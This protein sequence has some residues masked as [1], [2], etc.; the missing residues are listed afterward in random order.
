VSGVGQ[1]TRLCIHGAAGRVGRLLL[2][3]AQDDPS[4]TVVAAV[5]RPGSAAV[6]RTELELVGLGVGG[7]AIS[8]LVE[9]ALGQADVLIDFSQPEASARAIT[10]AAAAQVAI[11][12]GTTGLDDAAMAAI[13]AAAQRVAVVVA[14]N[15]SVGAVILND[16]ARKAAA[17]LGDGF[18]PEIV[19]VHHR[20]KKDA[21][22]GTA[23]SLAEALAFAT[24]RDLTRE[25]VTG[26]TGATGERPTA[27]LGVL[28]VR[29]GDVVGD[30]TVHFLGEG[31]RL[32][33]T[34]RAT[35]REL[36]ARGAIRA[37]RWAMGR[38]AG[39][40]DMRDVLGLG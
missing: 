9:T 23:L 36:F 31:E 11:V 18:D 22:S 28:A 12:V 24:G 26:R 27:Q 19:E 35:S 4:V 2:R 5:A 39:L 14:P 30:H 8:D 37:A 29:G 25:L 13:T 1:S 21:P 15:T 34:H 38:P 6:G 32:E 40:Y 20:R 7:V 33:L 16:L 3:V 17:A 10:A